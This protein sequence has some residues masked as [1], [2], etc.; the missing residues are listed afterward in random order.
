MPAE[1][2]DQ[3]RKLAASTPGTLLFE[4]SGPNTESRSH[5]FRAPL[6]IVTAETEAELPALIASLELA[7]EQGHHIAGMLHYEAGQAFE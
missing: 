7:L 6:Q 5:L 4:T 3:W 2:R 1:L